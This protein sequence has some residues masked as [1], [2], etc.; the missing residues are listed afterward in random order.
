M[1][2]YIRIGNYHEPTNCDECGGRMLYKGVGEYKCE[3]CGWV[4][5]DDYGKVRLYIEKHH[6]ATARE[7]EDATGV[8][9]KTIR[10]LLKEERIEVAPDSRVFIQC[11]FCG[12]SIRRGRFCPAC[13]RIF[14]EKEKILKEKQLKKMQGF[15][16]AVRGE[17]GAKRFERE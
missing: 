6:G 16:Q 15:G 11:E 14:T 8:R 2:P 5:Y 17:Q 13:E 3:D 10:Q 4:A 1:E 9:Q 12:V 7:I